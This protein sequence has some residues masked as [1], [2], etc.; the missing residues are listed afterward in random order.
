MKHPPMRDFGFYQRRKHDNWCAVPIPEPALE[1]PVADS[2]AHVHNLPDPAWEL[3]RCA[4]NGVR[5]VCEICD[6]S[7]DKLA[8]PDDVR[9]WR[10]SACAI[11]GETQGA[12]M[13]SPYSDEGIAMP[14]EKGLPEMRIAAGVHPHN[15]SLY[16]EEVEKRLMAWLAAPETTVMGEIGLDF[17]Y[18]LSPR[19]A[20]REVFRRQVQLAKELDLPVSLHLRGGKDP[21]A[22]NAHTEAFCILQEI[23]FPARGTILH[24]CS[25]PPDELSPWIEADCYVAYGGAITFKS[26]DAAREG[27]RL[28]PEN[29]L[30]LETDSPYMAPEPMRGVTCTPAHVLFTAAHLAEA[31]GI[32][33]GPNRE[34]FLARLF[35]NTLQITCSKE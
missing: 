10:K 34:R 17:H 5:F 13:A 35:E 6:P 32:A 7:E 30:L 20:Q 16:D 29:R 31:R 12:K 18:D 1:G 26:S 27:A 2:H 9:A 25:L 15:A 28:V 11:L 8:L 21:I 14:D 24:C 4:A 33:P 3:V 23:G 19:D 22:D